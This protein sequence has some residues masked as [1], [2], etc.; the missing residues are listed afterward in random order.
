MKSQSRIVTI[1]GWYMSLFTNLSNSNIGNKD[2]TII[3]KFNPGDL[4]RYIGLNRG[5]R[6]TNRDFN[7]NVFYHHTA[8]FYE[9]QG[10]ILSIVGEESIISNKEIISPDSLIT[11]L[12]CGLPEKFPAEL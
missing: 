7:E 5:S 1:Y 9:G 4:I 3:R 10:V 2:E 8:A 11:M 6:Y 12:W